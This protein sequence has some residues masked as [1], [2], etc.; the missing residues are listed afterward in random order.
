MQKLGEEDRTDLISE[1][2]WFRSGRR[3]EQVE[4][5]R[6][7][8]TFSEGDR[9][10]MIMLS[11]SASSRQRP[12]YFPLSTDYLLTLVHFNVFRALL[13]NMS[14]LSLPCLFSCEEPKTTIASLSAPLLETTRLPGKAIPE[15]L[16]PTPLQRSIP[17]E[18]WIDIFPLPALR[19]NL[20]RL[21]GTIDECDLCDDV[22]GT[23]YDEE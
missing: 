16:M 12:F 23:M 21:R 20:I 18:A 8:T 13:T 15:T 19:D 9:T 4:S 14:I 5:S 22:L 2:A 1:R 17:H 7:S 10:K 11:A 6:G 3:K